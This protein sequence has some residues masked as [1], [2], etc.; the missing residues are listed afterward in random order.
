MLSA[1][2]LFAGVAAGSG[3]MISDAAH[4]ASDVF[5]T[6]IVLA[7]VAMASKEADE[8][9]QYG[10]ERMECVAAI[11]LGAVLCATG[12]L[13]G[14]AGLQKIFSGNI[15]NLAVP[16]ALAMGAAL[17]SI[18][19]KEGMYWY[20]RNTAV[21]INSGALMADA[22]HHRSD[23]LS[24]V[25][26][27]IG[28]LGARMGFPV[29]DP[30]ASVVIC[31]FIIKAS[32]DIFADSVCKMIDE[33]CSRETV[34]QMKQ[35]ISR[36]PGVEGI[37]DIR[38]R[39]FGARIYVDVEICMDGSLTLKQAHETAEQVHLKVEEN[40]AEVKH[41]MVHVNPVKNEDGGIEEEKTK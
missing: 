8:K 21:K 5:S 30:L 22:W 6:V 3:A 12:I 15:K 11:L 38:T 20:T 31:I 17:V 25:G 33:S 41:C 14:A 36:Q 28:I 32:Y 39:K 13:I 23:A 7:G 37:D 10:H 4:S 27:F 26:S 35:I 1:F 19:V 16:G 24:S 34:E 29:L 2:K 18:A 40:F 9:H